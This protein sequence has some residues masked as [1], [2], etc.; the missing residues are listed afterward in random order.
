MHCRLASIN[1]LK[2]ILHHTLCLFLVS[3]LYTTRIFSYVLA[4]R[5][6]VEDIKGFLK[7]I[8]ATHGPN[9]IKKLFG[10]KTRKQIV[11]IGG[12][13]NIAN[14]ISGI[15][16]R[17]CIS[18]NK[19]HTLFPE[20]ETIDDLGHALQIGRN[21]LRN[22]R[23]VFT[24]VEQGDFEVLTSLGIKVNDNSLTEIQHCVS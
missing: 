9:F 7:Y 6:P 10:P 19:T 20:S 23:M 18:T 21:T 3:K 5:P 4:R 24:Q 22:L 11:K 17:I 16:S 8:L 2:G 14:I 15:I 12:V 13:G 1:I